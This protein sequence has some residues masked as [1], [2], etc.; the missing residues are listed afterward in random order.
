MWTNHQV[1]DV[2][3][4]QVDAEAAEVSDRL[5]DRVGFRRTMGR[6]FRRGPREAAET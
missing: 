2:I 5:D 6:A 3:H 4:R 1:Y